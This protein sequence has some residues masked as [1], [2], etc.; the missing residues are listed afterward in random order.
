MSARAAAGEPAGEKEHI[1][2]D[3]LKHR[4][5]AVKDLAV[6][7]AKD[8]ASRVAEMDATKKALIVIGVAVAVVSVAYFLG[9]RA[10]RFVGEE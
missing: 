7:E 8:A 2:L 9:T 4:A 1:S 5:E 3:D 6:S 10:G